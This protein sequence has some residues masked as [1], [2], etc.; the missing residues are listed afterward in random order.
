MFVFLNDLDTIMEALVKRKT[1]IAGRPSMKS[2]E[3]T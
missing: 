1:D 3:W 2:R